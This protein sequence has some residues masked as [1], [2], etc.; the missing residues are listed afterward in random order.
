MDGERPMPET[1]RITMDERSMREA[2]DW[3]VRLR[4]DSDDASTTGS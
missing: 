4:S 2:L 1:E 3:F